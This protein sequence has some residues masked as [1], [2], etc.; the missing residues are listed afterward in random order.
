[1]ESGMESEKWVFKISEGEKRP[2]SAW[3]KVFQSSC[4]PAF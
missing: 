1:M 3:K 4:S 2:E